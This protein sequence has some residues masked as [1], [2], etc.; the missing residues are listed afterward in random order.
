MVS[1][2]CTTGVD[3]RRESRQ[4]VRDIRISSRSGD[5]DERL[6]LR[7]PSGR[8]VWR[9]AAV[10]ARW[11]HLP[12]PASLSAGSGGRRRRDGVRRRLRVTPGQ[13][14]ARQPGRRR[15]PAHATAHARARPVCGGVVPA[16]CQ[17]YESSYPWP[18]A[19]P[20]SWAQ[21]PPGRGGS[22]ERGRRPRAQRPPLAD[23]GR[24]RSRGRRRRRCRGAGDRRPPGPGG[25]ERNPAAHDARHD[26]VRATR[27]P[28]PGAGAGAPLTLTQAPAVLS[29]YTTTNNSANAQRSDAMLARVESGSSYAIDAGLYQEQLADG[30]HYPAFGPV[31]ATY[32]IPRDEPAGRGPRWFVVQVANAFQSS[33]ATVTSDEYLLFTQSAPGGAWQDTIEPY[34][35]ASASAPQVAVGSD[36]LATA[37][38][39][40]SAAVAVAPSQ[41]PA[42][43]ASSLD[44]AV[45]GQAAVAVPGNLADRS[46]QKRWQAEVPGGTVTDAHARGGRRRR[47]GVRPA[48]RRRRRARLLHRRGPADDHSARRLDPPPERSRLLH[49]GPSRDP[50]R[51]LLPGAVRRLRPARRRRHSPR[52]RRLLRNHRQ[53]LVIG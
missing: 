48:H 42:A 19:P 50:G 22:S 1:V 30:T 34:L 53:E 35:L 7:P 2:A 40:D 32:Y 24:A 39:P 28:T 44:A 38:S 49:P 47:A 17:P 6:E 46:D 11:H 41:L 16:V 29:R 4:V 5:V 20:P 37:V 27:S 14:A 12:L 15:S 26:G 10:L 33:P 9:A 3:R 18:P 45:A 13:R 23:P 51:H 31:Q 25:H 36:G 21:G 52:R 8:A 43:T